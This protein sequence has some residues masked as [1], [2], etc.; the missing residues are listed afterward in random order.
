MAG[1]SA[2]TV[3]RVLNDTAPVAEETR[4]RVLAAVAELSYSPNAFARSLATNRSGGIGVSVNDLGSPYYGAMLQGIEAEVE[5]AGMHLLVSSGGANAQKERKSIEFLL[6]RRSD[7]LIVHLEATP[8]YELLELM[9]GDVPVVLVGRHL[10]D[11]SKRSVYLDNEAGGELAAQYLIE[12]GHRRI[13]HVSGPL[14]FPDARARLQGYRRALEL[15]GIRHDEQLLVEADF[16]EDGGRQAVER[17]LARETDFS[18]V[19]FAND[20]MAAGGAQA[21]RVAGLRIPDDVSIMGYDDV[22]IARYLSPGLTTIHQPLMEMGRAAARI[23][24]DI[25]EGREREEVRRKFEPQLVERDSVK[26]IGAEVAA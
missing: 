18:A 7:A 15:A 5:G 10:A 24:L 14:S 6:G 1:V 16:L 20:Q 21:L 3:S 22:L 8:D 4:R 9:R 19:F 2:S 11:A 12:R 26:R 17:L 25:L 23:A 13:A